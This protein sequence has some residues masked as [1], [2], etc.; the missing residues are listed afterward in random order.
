[1]LYFWAFELR[2]NLH[3]DS[4]VTAIP[5]ATHPDN[6]L[7]ISSSRNKHLYSLALS[8]MTHAKY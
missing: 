1:V 6:T 5:L 8:L 3:S 2:F 4:L 7:A